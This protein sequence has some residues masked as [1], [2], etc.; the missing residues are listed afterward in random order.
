MLDWI[1]WQQIPSDAARTLA[2]RILSRPIGVGIQVGV[3]TA[4]LPFYAKAG[5][6]RVLVV[7]QGAP[8]QFAHVYAI[9]GDDDAWLLDG[10]SA[11]VHDANDALKVQVTAETAADYVRFFTFA[12]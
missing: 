6:A 4:A 10:T 9:V 1:Q 12:V 8:Q 5:L 11:P 7:N 2:A 3:S